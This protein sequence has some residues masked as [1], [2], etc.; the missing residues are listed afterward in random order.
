MAAVM[1]AAYLAIL[2]GPAYFVARQLQRAGQ[3]AAWRALRFIGPLQLVTAF[4]L[5]FAADAIGLPNPA[6]MFV[7]ATATSSA[8]G[9]AVCKLLGWYAARP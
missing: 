9:A 1:A 5:A 4:A 6:G 7:A 8:A 2:W 3:L